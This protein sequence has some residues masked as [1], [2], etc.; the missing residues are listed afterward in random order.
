MLLHCE[1]CEA[2]TSSDQLDRERGNELREGIEL[3][4][5][6]KALCRG[7]ALQGELPY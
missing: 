2:V 7:D 3:C 5:A 6:L 4:L 1:L